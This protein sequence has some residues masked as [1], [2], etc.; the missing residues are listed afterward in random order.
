MKYPLL[1]SVTRLRVGYVRLV[2]FSSFTFL[3]DCLLLYAE[4]FFYRFIFYIIVYANLNSVPWRLSK[5]DFIFSVCTTSNPIIFFAFTLLLLHVNYIQLQRRS[6]N[7]HGLT[8]KT[9]RILDLQLVLVNASK[10]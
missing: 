1:I 8:I 4:H 10:K 5:I 2:F 7:F 9:K 3:K 6:N